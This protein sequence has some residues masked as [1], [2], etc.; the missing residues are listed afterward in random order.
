MNLLKDS[1]CRLGLCVLGPIVDVVVVV[2]TKKPFRSPICKRRT[3]PVSC[4]SDGLGPSDRLLPV[5]H[6][7]TTPKRHKSEKQTRKQQD[8]EKMTQAR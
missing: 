8:P 2:F 5:G 4:A 6:R 7:Q 1:P 3:G